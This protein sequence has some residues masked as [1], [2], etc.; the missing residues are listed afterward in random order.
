[1]D[2]SCITTLAVNWQSS[3]NISSCCSYGRYDCF[4]FCTWM[5]HRHDPESKWSCLYRSSSGLR[6]WSK[7]LLSW[8][9]YEV[10]SSLFVLH[11]GHSRQKV[12]CLWSLTPAVLS[13]LKEK[14]KRQCPLLPLAYQRT[15]CF[16]LVN[17]IY[18]NIC[19]RVL[20]FEWL[21]TE[22]ICISNRFIPLR[23]I[24]DQSVWK[25]LLQ[26]ENISMALCVQSIQIPTAE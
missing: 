22:A 15:T 18:I 19:R 25:Q 21:H 16:S 24:P 26:E 17:L 4:S 7:D 3:C 20:T 23:V 13:H 12:Q 5:C 2:L 9:H 11:S 6:C 14:A 10:F 1:M 8:E